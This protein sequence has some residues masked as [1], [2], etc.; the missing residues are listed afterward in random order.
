MEQGPK[1]MAWLLLVFAGFLEVLWLFAM[2][3][4][5]GFKNWQSGL[6]SIVAASASFFLLAYVLKYIPAGT[7]Y[8][9]WS[10][11]GAIGTA[12]I[13]ILVFGERRNFLRII[14]IGLIIFGIVGLKLAT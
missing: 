7:A 5:D 2:K 10:G 6:L 11:I 9:V 1:Q 12:I 3:Q 13:G 8:A 4:S 14:S